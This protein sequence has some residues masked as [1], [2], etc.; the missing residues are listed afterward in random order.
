MPATISDVQGAANVIKQNVGRV[1]VGKDRVV[2]LMLVALFCEGHVLLEDV[3]GIGKTTLAKSLARS[4]GCDFSRIQFTPDLLPTDITGVS[5]YSQK[6]QEFEYRPGP[7]IS[8]IVLADEINRAGPRTQ[9]ALLEAMQEQQVTVDGVTRPL[10]RPFLVL[11]TQNPIELEG[12]F[13]LPE[14]QVDRFLM[15]LSLGYPDVDEE[16]TIL[17]R[18]RETDPLTT[19]APV[20]SGQQALELGQRCRQVQVTQGIEGYMIAVVQASRSNEALA[21]GASPRGTMSL[22]RTCQALAAIHGRD[23]V[24]PDDVQYLIHPVL[25]HR[26][27]LSPESRLRGR[28]ADEVLT[29]ILDRVPVPVEESWSVQDRE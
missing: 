17:R 15:R 2:E 16:R 19:L 10:P 7:I 20:V 27:I 3:P 25:S 1:I 13:P 9:S 22:Y 11:A 26:L 28:T 29:E 4:L 6:S 24:Q 12:T 18:F 14:A 5:V 23:Y 8:Q 21:L